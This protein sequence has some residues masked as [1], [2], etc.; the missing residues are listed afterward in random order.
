M[1]NFNPLEHG[2]KRVGAKSFNPLAHGAKLVNKSE[3]PS[4]G[5]RIASG[6]K[7]V[8]SG[9][10]GAI[11]DTVA[12]AYNIPASLHNMQ[13]HNNKN[14]GEDQRMMNE[15]LARFNPDYIGHG[16]TEEVPLI[17]SATEAID[18]GIDKVTGG[19]T[20]TPEDQKYVNEVLKFGSSF[21]TGGAVS[22][23]GSNLGREGISK[24]GS[25]LGNANP[26]QIAGAGAAGGVMSNLS[27]QGA[28]TGETLGK[29]LATNL[30]VSSIPE[31][32]KGGG[33]LVTKAALGA[34]GLGKSKLN[35]EA[36][37]A[38]RDLDIVLPKAAVT[39]S[40]AVALADQFLSKTPI[41]GSVMQ[42][43]YA[44]I[45][46]KVTK[47]LD[48]I[49]DSIIS[50][51]E[52]EN[53][54]ETIKALY[55][56]SVETLPEKA[57]VMPKHTLER[58]EQIKNSINT[59]S[60]SPDEKTLLNEISN[61]EQYFMPSGI[62]NIP[63]PVK[64]LVGTKRS[65][66]G[67]IKWDMDIGIQNRLKGI[68]KAIQQDVEEYGKMNQDWYKFYKQADEL[69]GKVSKREELES[70]L[71]KATNP[72]TDELSYN[73]LSKIINNRKS[74][75]QLSKLTGEKTFN[76][77]RKLGEVSK[78]LAVK[79]KNVP[80]PSGT[81]V[82]QSTFSFISGLTGAGAIVDPVSTGVTLLGA[83]SIAHL[84]TDKKTLDLAIKFAEK[85]TQSD[86]IRFSRRMKEIT[87]YTP[88]TLLRAAQD[89]TRKEQE[90]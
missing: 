44:K 19:Y 65:L 40:K 62:K 59:A 66:N 51:K 34:V 45:G 72:A 36:A 70:L 21:A 54:D 41:A 55:K 33:N 71:G 16:A 86:A 23:L 90:Q 13:A 4:I 77:I 87:G 61:I 42:D 84:L 2:A 24:A 43:R 78:A 79:N 82:T 49:Y 83:T 14:L 31:M 56:K 76:K 11:P 3:E 58:V 63:A 57:E 29:G 25:Y 64:Y 80:N 32:A 28:S 20:K 75:S 39:P 53:A 35:L 50:P 10:A 12:L 73:S 22:K 81:A 5:N 89:S 52:L 30:A 88:I 38:A 85:P 47:T 37:K 74:A 9:I 15:S 7:S 18:K 26:W 1:N 48:N 69:Y 6:V 46:K 67:T 68:Q 27:D 60:P 17:P 8:V